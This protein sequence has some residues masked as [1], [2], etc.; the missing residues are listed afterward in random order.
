FVPVNVGGL[1]E[2]LADAELF[3]H[4]KGAFTGAVV[5]RVGAFQQAGAGTLF[6]D[7][8]ADLAPAVQVKLL[9]VLEERVVRPLGGAAPVPVRARI[10]S[11]CWAAIDEPGGPVGFRRDLFHR[12]ATVVLRIPPLRQR[13]ADISAL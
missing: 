11:A 7:E 2:A 3:G 10:V 8:V 1:S 12:I 6:L 9:R 13:K 5:A 4:A